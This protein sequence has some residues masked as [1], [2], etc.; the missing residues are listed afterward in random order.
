MSEARLVG[1]GRFRT[2]LELLPDERVLWEGGA[3]PRAAWVHLLRTW[4]IVFALLGFLLIFLDMKHKAHRSAEARAEHAAQVAKSC[5]KPRAGVAAASSAA[6]TSPVPSARKATRVDDGAD[7]GD[8]VAA[9]L[10]ATVLLG[11]FAFVLLGSLAL[12]ADCVLRVR[13]AWYV[14][15]SE[16]VCIQSG[17]WSRTLTVMDLDKVISVRSYASWLEARLGLQ[18][19]ELTHAGGALV[20]TNAWQLLMPSPYAIAHVAAEGKLM[21]ELVNHWLPRDDRR[22]G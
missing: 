11:M 10:L 13:R 14:I 22:S 1:E 20:A 18:S 7:T 3:R 17:G 9:A 4:W 6:P 21:S 5:P 8:L 16:R 19:I 2:P 12:L 15:T